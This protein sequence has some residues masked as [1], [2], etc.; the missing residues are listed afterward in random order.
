MSFF[1]DIGKAI[2]HA[3]AWV[4]HEATDPAARKQ[5][6]TVIAEVAKLGLMFPDNTLV[7]KGA[8][9]VEDAVSKVEGALGS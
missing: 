5:A 8:T 9:K 3:A 1:S 2:G 7:Y 6:L 4:G